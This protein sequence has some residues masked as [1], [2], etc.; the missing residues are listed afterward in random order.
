MPKRGQSGQTLKR[1]SDFVL[2][3]G[4]N[5]DQKHEEYIP[6]S[7]QGKFSFFF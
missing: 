3:I 6:A 5:G 1:K 2:T 4:K 7:Q